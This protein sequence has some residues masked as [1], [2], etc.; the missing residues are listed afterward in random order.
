M[1]KRK[2]EEKKDIE[3]MSTQGHRLNMGW[4]VGGGG[5]GGIYVMLTFNVD[6]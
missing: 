5:G 2:K 4:G 3:D 1:Q 6:I